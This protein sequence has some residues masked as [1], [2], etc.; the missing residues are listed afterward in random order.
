MKGLD[1]NLQL[2]PGHLSATELQKI[3]H[4]SIEHIIP[5]VQGSI[6]LISC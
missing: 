4:I 2:F 5:K 3:T 1:P 6:A